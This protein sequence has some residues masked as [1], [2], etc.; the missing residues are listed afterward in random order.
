MFMM[1]GKALDYNVKDELAG[2]IQEFNQKKRALK[3]SNKHVEE[4]KKMYTQAKLMFFENGKHF[5]SAY[6]KYNSDFTFG[7]DG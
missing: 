1:Y 6:D 7:G 5:V 2:E 4:V 3:F